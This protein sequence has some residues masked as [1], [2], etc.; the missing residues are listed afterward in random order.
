[1]SDE[2]SIPIKIAD[3]I[4]RGAYAN[5][6]VVRHTRE[7]FVLDFLS[8]FP[9][10]AVVNARVIVSPGH[11]KRILR[12]LEDNVLKYESAHGRIADAEPPTAGP[13]N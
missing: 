6:M 5:Q 1:M 10:E 7:E 11:M 12:A 4:L 8:V 2:R 3:E 13:A 9:P